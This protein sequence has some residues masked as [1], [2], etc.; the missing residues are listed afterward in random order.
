MWVEGFMN[1]LSGMNIL[2]LF[3]GT[4]IGLVVGVLPALGAAFGVAL[5]LPFTFGMDAAGA[6]ILLCAIHASCNYGDSITSILLNVPGSAATVASC[7]D[8]YPLAQQGRGGEALGIATFSSFI[9]GL[10]VWLLLVLL[11]TPITKIALSFG[12][13][14]YFALMIMALGLISVAAKGETLKGLIMVCM[15][16]ALSAVGQD[17]VLGTTFRFAY[18]IPWLEAGIPIVVSTLGIFAIPQ[19][20]DMLEEGGTVAK[21]IEAKDS[22]L[23]GAMAPFRRP[24]TLL[25]SGSVGAFVGILP[26]LGTGLAGIASYLTEKKYSKEASQFGKGSPGGLV[27]AEVGKGACVIGDLVPTFTLGVP[28]S[29]T[30]AILLA[31]LIMQGIQPGPKFLLSGS[32]PYTVI[33]GLLLAQATFLILGLLIGKQLCRIVYLPNT[34]LAPVLTILVFLGAYEAQNSAFDILVSLVFGLFAY[35]LVKLGYPIVCL[36]LGLIL[37]AITEANFIRALGESFGSYSVFVTRPIALSMILITIIFLLGPYLIYFFR[38][39]RKQPAGLIEEAL[40]GE[41]SSHGY[42]G[43]LAL[44]LIVTAVFI[45]FLYTARHYSALVKLFPNVFCIAGL[46][47]TLW[48]SA[49]IIRHVSASRSWGGT[50]SSPSPS[51]SLFRGSLSWRWAIATL[52]GYLFSIY[53]FGFVLASAL[54]ITGVVAITSG[55]RK[56]W[57]AVLTGILVGGGLFILAKGARL[58]FPVGLLTGV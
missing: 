54:Y 56:W 25:R 17:E 45:T 50:K 24:L 43:E 39:S 41:K 42:K 4:S 30:G 2:W 46:G 20:I 11:V 9:G 16:L 18:G 13:P 21:C 49:V 15:G 1:A 12:S 19:V 44:L 29:V 6:I 57:L 5:A 26:A 55:R 38:R 53:L 36:V 33:A 35:V 10:A 51:F 27:A 47:F 32:L 34:I 22:V 58:L 37:G 3:I 40:A 23:R 14:E 28:G 31:A 7:W 48:R 52:F 8:G